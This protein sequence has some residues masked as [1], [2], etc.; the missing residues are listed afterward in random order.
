VLL[1]LVASAAVAVSGVVPHGDEDQTCLVCK[2]RHQPQQAQVGLLCL[3]APPAEA[4]AAVPIDR[5]VARSV[6]LASISP[7]APPA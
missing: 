5:F 2:I 6:A 7:R 1:T 4:V 3:E